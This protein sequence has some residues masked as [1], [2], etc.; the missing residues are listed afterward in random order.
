[1]AATATRARLTTALLAARPGLAEPL[2]FTLQRE[3]IHVTS[4]V[5]KRLANDV[6]YLRLKQFQEGTHDE[7]LQTSAL[8]GEIIDSQFGG[9]HHDLFEIPDEPELAQR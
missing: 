2:T 8:Y 1:M 7:L 5:G 9:D 3:E 4:V 6:A